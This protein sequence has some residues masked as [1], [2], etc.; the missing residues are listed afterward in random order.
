LDPRELDALSEVTDD[1]QALGDAHLQKAV[2]TFRLELAKSNLETDTFTFRF[3]AV[4]ELAK[5]FSTGW[6]TSY[7]SPSMAVP[8][9]TD[10][11]VAWLVNNKVRAGP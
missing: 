5:M 7:D 9:E 8:L 11:L 1:I 2:L 3:H 4:K 6:S 10:V